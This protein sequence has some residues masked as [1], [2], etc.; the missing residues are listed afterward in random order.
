MNSVIVTVKTTKDDLITCLGEAEPVES[1][2]I[3]DVAKQIFG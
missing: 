2:D 3:Y 1:G